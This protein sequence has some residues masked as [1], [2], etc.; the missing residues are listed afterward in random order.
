MQTYRQHET[1]TPADNE[2]PCDV[3]QQP[4]ADYRGGSA[5]WDLNRYKIRDRW[6]PVKL[7]LPTVLTALLCAMVTRARSLRTVKQRTAQMARKLGSWLGV[8]RRIA[9]NTFGKVLPRLRLW[10]LVACL[11]SPGRRPGTQ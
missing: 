10:N 2:E 1:S 11:H 9:D 4:A 5:S 3:K 7:P 8:K 6:A